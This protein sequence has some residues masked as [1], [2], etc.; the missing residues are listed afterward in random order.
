MERERWAREVHD[1]LA[2]GFV[3]MITLSQAARSELAAGAPRGRGLQARPARG[4]GPRQ[5]RRGA[6]ARGGRG[7]QHPAHRRSRAGPGPARRGPAPGWAPRRPERRPARGAPAHRR[8][9]G[10]AHRPGGPVQCRPPLR[11]AGGPRQ[12]VLSACR[13]AERARHRGGRRRRGGR[14][15]ARGH[16]AD[17][18][19][20]S[21]GGGADDL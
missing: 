13:W 8:G 21:A 16:G 19:P 11:G 9:D 20:G 2:Q 6:V 14:R 3:S 10:P 15:A 18:R 5:P 4:G 17:R 12:R 7:P 1:T